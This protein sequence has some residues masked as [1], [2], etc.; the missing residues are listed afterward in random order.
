MP[1]GRRLQYTWTAEQSSGLI[2]NFYC[3][4]LKFDASLAF[5][6]FNP[7]CKLFETASRSVDV[8]VPARCQTIL[9]A[10]PELVKC[11]RIHLFNLRKILF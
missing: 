4:V 1:T 8:S 3:K 9:P 7:V 10:I 5:F 6:P 2:A 11:S